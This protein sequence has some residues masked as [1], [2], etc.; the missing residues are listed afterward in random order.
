MKGGNRQRCSP[1]AP[2][3]VAVAVEEEEEE[4]VVVVVVRRE[5]PDQTR[6]GRESKAR[7]GKARQGEASR[8]KAQQLSEWWCMA[9]MEG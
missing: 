9:V 2:A 1:C 5:A 3:A 8:G 6:F 7:Q 4:E